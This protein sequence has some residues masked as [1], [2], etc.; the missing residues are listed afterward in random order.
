MFLESL[1]NEIFSF[2]LVSSVKEVESDPIM[3]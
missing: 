1:Q 2:L 3:F